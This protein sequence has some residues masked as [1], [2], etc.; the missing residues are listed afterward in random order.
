MRKLP[1]GFG[2]AALLASP[3]SLWAQKNPTMC[4][5]VT[6]NCDCTNPPRKFVVEDQRVGKVNPGDPGVC[7]SSVYIDDWLK[8]N[9]YTACVRGGQQ[10]FDPQKPPA[11]KATW[12]CKETCAESGK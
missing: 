11:C 12:T 7:Q 8:K 6:L 9:P 3:N 10:G 5:V 4:R 2:L 1:L